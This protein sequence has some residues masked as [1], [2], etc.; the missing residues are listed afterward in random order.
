M[1]EEIWKWIPGFEEQY[2]VSNLGYIRSF[3]AYKRGELMTGSKT[4]DGRIRV[5]LNGKKYL[6]HR[7]VLMTFN[8]DGQTELKNMVLHLDGDPTNNSL[9]N[10]KWGSASENANDEICI[11]RNIE[12]VQKSK[13]RRELEQK[14]V[15]EG[16]IWKDI[17]GYNGD[18]Q[19]S[20]KGRVKSLKNKNP[21][22]M[23]LIQ[24]TTSNYYCIGLCKDNHKKKYSVD[25]LVAEAFIPNPN[26]YSEINHINKDTL[27][28]RV[29]N[30]EWCTHSQNVQHSI[31]RQG[32][33]VQQFTLDGQLLNTFESLAEAERQTNIYR[34]NISN[35][36]DKVNRTAG[37]F[38]WRRA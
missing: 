30:L 35:A 29:E 37:G 1:E 23:S 36:L 26:N 25:R 2:Q 21:L 24:Q 5:N 18:Y 32:I 38:I 7:L 28:N 15:I 20:N 19:I 31:Y 27:D 13:E 8:P 3:K 6:V 10:L 4:K 17:E 11:K 16:E 33:R 34:P 14:I 22:I 9:S 12:T